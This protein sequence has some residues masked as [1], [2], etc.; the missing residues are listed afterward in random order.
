MPCS[1]ACAAPTS[2]TPSSPLEP[3]G[4]RACRSRACAP[5]LVPGPDRGD[6]RRRRRPARPRHVCQPR[7]VRGGEPRRGRRPH[8]GRGAAARPGR[9]RVLRGSPARAPRHGDGVDGVLHDLQRRRGRRVA[10]RPGR[11]GDGLRLRR[12]PR[13]RHAGGLLRRP[14]R[15][16]RQPATSGRCTPAPATS[17]R[18]AAA[19]ARAP[20][21]TSRCRQARRAMC[22][23]R[24]S[25]R[26]S[27][28]SRERFAPTWVIVSAGFDAHRDDP[29]TELG[30][31]AGDYGPLTRPCAVAGARRA[32]AS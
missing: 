24:R 7:V 16:V 28:R 2:P 18:R 32:G 21:S 1:R 13:Q 5:R 6:L 25:T 26:S 10:G 31:A 11:A 23:C 8:R 20:R 15:A 14:A 3:R 27:R 22:T 30:L 29:I 12:P 9:R 19:P 4:R 17:T